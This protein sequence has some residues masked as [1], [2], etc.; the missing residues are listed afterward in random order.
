MRDGQS[1]LPR[2][3]KSEPWS[4]DSRRTFGMRPICHRKQ[5]RVQPPVASK[6]GP[7]RIA[8]PV[9]R[10]WMGGPSAPHATPSLV[11]SR[12]SYAH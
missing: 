1:E 5:R 9:W 10:A 12:T 2:E 7:G 4:A 11:G 8:L 3:A 6:H